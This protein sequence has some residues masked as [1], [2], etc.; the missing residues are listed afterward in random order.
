LNAI[1]KSGLKNSPHGC[2]VIVMDNHYSSPTLFVTLLQHYDVAAIGTVRKN[3]K[4]L[5]KDLLTLAK[6]AE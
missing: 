2:R 5:D 3:R 1:E 6:G 4:G